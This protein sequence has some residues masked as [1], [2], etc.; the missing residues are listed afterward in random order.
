MQSISPSGFTVALRQKERRAYTELVP[1]AKYKLDSQ[2]QAGTG[3]SGSEVTS[4][5]IK[6]RVSGGRVTPS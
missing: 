6:E 5:E 4:S 2:D 3:R 1:Y